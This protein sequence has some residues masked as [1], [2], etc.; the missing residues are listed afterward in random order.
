M[1]SPWRPRSS[2]KAADAPQTA[3]QAHRVEAVQELRVNAAGR[4]PR[5]PA[6]RHRLRLTLVVAAHLSR[7]SAATVRPLP[8]SLCSAGCR[9]LFTF[10]R[11]GCRGRAWSPTTRR[12][13]ICFRRP[14]CRSITSTRGVGNV[15]VPVRNPHSLTHVRRRAAGAARSRRRRDDGAPASA[16]TW[17]RTAPTDAAPTACGAAAVLGSGRASPS[18][19]AVRCAC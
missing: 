19:R 2:I 7:S 15:L 3:S 18:A 1:P 5:D 16:S 10:R 13:S 6:G 17:P 8:P 9:S 14:S 11:E 4:P 12:R